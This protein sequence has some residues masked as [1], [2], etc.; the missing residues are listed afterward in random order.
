MISIIT[1][2]NNKKILEEYLLKSLAKQT[3]NYELVAID[4]TDNKRFQDA[5]KALNYGAS[6]AKG[7]YLMFIHQ[8]VALLG[9]SFL[10]KFEKMLR[11]IDDIGIGGVAGMTQ[12]GR[13]YLF[14]KNDGALSGFPFLNPVKVQTLDEMLLVIPRHVFNIIHFDYNLPGWHCYGADYCLEV[15]K[16]NL[17][18]YVLPFFV[19]HGSAGLRHKGLMNS[20]N[21]MRKKWRRKICHTSWHITEDGEIILR[22]IKPLDYTLI[23]DVISHLFGLVIFKKKSLFYFPLNHSE[24][25]TLPLMF[26][27]EKLNVY[28]SHEYP[29]TVIVASPDELLK[30]VK[31]KYNIAYLIPTGQGVNLN[32]AANALKLV[33]KRII[34]RGRHANLIKLYFWNIFS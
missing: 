21:Y 19:H 14:L 13:S 9:D 28:D 12:K 27:V 33:A 5:T 15:E 20:L 24:D 8:D 25:L 18:T 11:R 34:V 7:E 23:R 22:D 10:E 31:E 4:N 1:I 26:T 16:F 17:C 6:F 30:M 29:I 3:V 2:Y 32:E